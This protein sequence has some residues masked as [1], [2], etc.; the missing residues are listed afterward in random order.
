MCHS[1]LYLCDSWDL[2]CS[3]KTHVLKTWS[4]GECCWEAV[5]PLKDW[6]SEKSLGDWGYSLEEDCG[7]PVPSFSHFCFL[8]IS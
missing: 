2:E 3:P 8:A 4:P 1:F 6:P 5:E 7:T